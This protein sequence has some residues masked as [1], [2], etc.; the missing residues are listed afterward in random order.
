MAS[1]RALIGI[2]ETTSESMVS[3]GSSLP[4]EPAWRR[5]ATIG[6]ILA[7]CDQGSE[8]VQA[9]RT[10]LALGYLVDIQERYMHKL[11]LPHLKILARY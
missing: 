6:G 4:A 11:T 9:W 1:E 7:A 10:T 5:F 2:R 8:N 3:Q